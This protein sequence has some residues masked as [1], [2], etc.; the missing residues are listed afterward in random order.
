MITEKKGIYA[1]AA[2][3][4]YYKYLNT[5]LYAFSEHNNYEKIYVCIE[6]KELN[7]PFRDLEYID[8]DEYLDINGA[9]Y[10]GL[11]GKGALIRLY[12]P[13]IVKED[14]I[15]YMDL[16]TIVVDDISELFDIDIENYYC[17]GVFDHYMK[18]QPLNTILDIDYDNYI[19]AGVI[20]FNLEYVRKDKKDKELIEY[21]N[22]TKLTYLDQDT[23]NK[24]FYGKIKLIDSIY[25]SCGATETKDNFKIYHWVGSKSNWVYERE[26]SNLWTDVEE[27]Y[28]S[29]DFI[30]KVTKNTK[31]VIVKEK[32]KKH[33]KLSII[34]TYY[35]QLEYIKE[36]YN[37]LYPQIN[38]S[39]ELIIVDD[40]CHDSNLSNFDANIIHLKDN[41]GIAGAR[42]AGL[43]FAHGDYIA[44][45]DGDD[46]PAKN[47]VELIL[48]NIEKYPDKDYLIFNFAF[49]DGYNYTVNEDNSFHSSNAWGKVYKREIIGDERFTKRFF[50]DIGFNNKILY[51]KTY[52]YIKEILL[53]YRTNNNDSLCHRAGRKEIYHYCKNIFFIDNIDNNSIKLL[54]N[55]S[56]KYDK[57]IYVYR[58][59]ISTDT[60]GFMYKTL[61]LCQMGCVNIRCNHFFNDSKYQSFPHLL[62]NHIYL[63]ITSSK[64]LDLYHHYKPSFIYDAYIALDEEIQ[65]KY[66]KIYGIK[67]MLFKDI[68]SILERDE[69]E[70]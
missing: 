66:E 62:Y 50:E 55:L 27:K 26:N 43:D 22:S 16:D 15:L 10:N 67:T 37:I 17:A 11:D 57:D 23:I 54:E 14:K 25:N 42:N 33:L 52:S 39:V 21:I 30:L 19:N 29:K 49:W 31:K 18:N 41:S 65:E 45:I 60:S 61:G 64:D 6:D 44:F 70:C 47:Y 28:N 2:T 20:L 53:Y 69:N 34:V 9:N 4:K 40:G 8:M 46:L 36:L 3:R 68:D 32:E 59:T 56:N 35:K 13:E 12:L 5:W 7:L 1:V 63:L 58:N 48:K 51:K 38:D 24:V